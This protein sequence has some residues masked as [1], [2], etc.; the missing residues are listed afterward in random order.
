MAHPDSAFYHG[1]SKF[2]KI[3]IYANA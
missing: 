3:N 1:L 2:R